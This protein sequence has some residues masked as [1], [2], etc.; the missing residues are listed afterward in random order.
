MQRRFDV[1]FVV[2]IVATLFFFSCFIKV[3]EA[4]Y[5]FPNYM[6]CILVNRVFKLMK[7]M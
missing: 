4:V 6:K 3:T 7:G 5:P 2:L 1:I